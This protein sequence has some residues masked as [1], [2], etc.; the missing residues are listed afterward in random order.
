MAKL[1][2]IAIASAAFV[3]Q[4]A[5]AACATA[6]YASCG[7]NAGTTCCPD[8]YYCQPWDA[9]FFQC[10]PQP[11]QCTQQL[12][13]V[14]LS[15]ATL[16]TL[17]GI[18]PIDCCTKCAQTNGCVGY[19][20]VNSN[21]GQPVCYLKSALGS[22]QTS[23]GAV[24]GI[25]NS[26]TVAPTPTPTPSPSVTPTPTTTSS[27]SPST[28]ATAAF[29]SCGSSATGASCCPSGYYCQPWNADFYQCI[30][31]PAQCSA[32]LPDTD[33]YGNDLQTVYV[34]LPSLCCQACAQL[35]G[36]KAYT[37][38]NNNPGQPVCYLKSAAGN[39]TKLVGAVAGK[40][41]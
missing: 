10:M 37:Y 26:V 7:S 30:A 22:S 25:I 5:E 18:Q 38:I 23:V 9:G 16:N 41:N 14:M 27:P 6:P 36:C 13:N 34:S 29:A 35:A 11:A 20:F 28:C 15:G 4:T 19:S 39:P 32:Q 31:P 2:A 3:G 1:L 21:P 33:Y 12:T 17:Y 24:S 8:A 40:L